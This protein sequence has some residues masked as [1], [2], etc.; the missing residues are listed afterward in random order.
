MYEQERT[1]FERDGFVVVRD[2][3]DE[4]EFGELR[5]NVDRYIRDIVPRL[6]E[7]DA[8]Y[9]DRS[10]PETLKQLQNMGQD[11]FFA[12]YQRH[13]RWVELAESLLTEDSATMGGEWFNKPPATEHATPPH[14][15]NYYFN[16]TPPNVLTIWMAL[17]QVDEENGCLRYLPGSHKHG[18]RPH[19]PTQTLGFSQ[20]VA[21]YSEQEAQREVSIC[22]APG[23]AVVHHGNVIHSARANRSTTRHRPAFAM[24]IKGASCQRDEEGFA[25]YLAAST[26]QRAALTGDEG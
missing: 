12:A 9:Q 17:E 22:L 26:A 11:S 16:L 6:P 13:D 25:R 3:L 23:E 4:Q 19:A 8:F 15:D 24:V 18:V 14:Q 20:G 10:R 1:D 2:L 7:S 5:S 21:D